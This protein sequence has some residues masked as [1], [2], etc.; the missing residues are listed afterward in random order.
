[1]NLEEIK[2]FLKSTRDTDIEEIRYKN[3][4]CYL[5]FKKGDLTV[6]TVAPPAATDANA[7]NETATGEEKKEEKEKKISFSSVR[8]TMVG[9]FINAQDD[10]KSPFV[11]EG[12]DISVGQKIGQIEAM[13]ILKDVHSEVKGRVLKVLV[14]SGQPV[15]YGQ[16][17]FL[18]DNTEK[19]DEE[20]DTETEENE[21]KIA[22]KPE[23]ADKQ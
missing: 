6:T 3:D 1:L 23:T 12:D 20:T 18:I 5:Y 14:S 22:D 13:K 16:E 2:E 11:K 15:E 9:T 10:G 4:K 19:A 17:L 8:S 21:N 7:L